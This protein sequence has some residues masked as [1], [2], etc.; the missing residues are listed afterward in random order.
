MLVYWGIRFF[1][2]EAA[3]RTG[4]RPPEKRRK[5]QRDWSGALLKSF[6]LGIFFIRLI[7]DFDFFGNHFDAEVEVIR[8]ARH[9]FDTAVF[10]EQV[11]LV[12]L[13]KEF[14]EFLLKFDALVGVFEYALA[15]GFSKLFQ[16]LPV[17]VRQRFSLREY[18]IR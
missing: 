18:V 17:Q 16:P 4:I 9:D 14:V 7:R 8:E 11:Q 5:E 12:Q 2:K 3:R 10:M 6:L 15:F 1:R 13:E